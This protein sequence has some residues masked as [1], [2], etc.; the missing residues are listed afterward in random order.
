MSDV[1]F[2]EQVVLEELLDEE[3]GC[4]MEHINIPCSEVVTHMIRPSCMPASAR[5]C[6]T[7]A[8]TKKMQQQ[9]FGVCK[10]DRLALDCWQIYPI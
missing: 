4:E 1:G 9:L 8:Q 2:M 5:M 6:E 3:L 7:S 10:C